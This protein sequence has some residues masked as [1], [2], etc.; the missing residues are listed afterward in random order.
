ML[1]SNG[2]EA[3]IKKWG[4]ENLHSSLYHIEVSYDFPGLEIEISPCSSIHNKNVY[5]DKIILHSRL[6]ESELL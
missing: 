1:I 5:Q 4:I 2:Y 6:T 3:A